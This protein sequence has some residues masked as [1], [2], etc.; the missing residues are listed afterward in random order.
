MRKRY[1]KTIVAM[2]LQVQAAIAAH[3]VPGIG[4]AGGRCSLFWYYWLPEH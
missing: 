1:N 2:I 4:K 3:P